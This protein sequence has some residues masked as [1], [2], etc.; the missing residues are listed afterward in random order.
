MEKLEKAKRYLNLLSEG[1]DPI[2][3]QAA[4]LETLQR[5]EIKNSFKYAAN[6]IGEVIDNGGEII[7]VTKPIEF[8]YKS[9]NLSDVKISEKPVALSTL[10]GNINK[11]LTN[12]K[13]K[14]LGA[15]SIKSWLLN[16]GYVCE[17]K[18]AVVKNVSELRLTDKSLSIGIIQEES[19]DK[20]TGEIKTSIKLT[21]EAQKY[22]IDNLDK[23]SSNSENN[24]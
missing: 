13:M 21:K 5:Q 11:Q 4:T 15:A 1:L 10:V 19:V 23:I 12:D 3:N 7:Q 24:Q 2:T 17:E 22:I 18:V 6:I 9:V 8:D 20:T 14:N 16:N